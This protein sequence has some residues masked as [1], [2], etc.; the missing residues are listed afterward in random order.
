MKA[1]LMRLRLGMMILW[2]GLALL[3]AL[4]T[5]S[6]AL[7]HATLVRSNPAAN[8]VVAQIPSEIRL[9]FSEA[10]EPRFSSFML[11]DQSGKP[12]DTPA[13]QID[14]ADATQMAMRPGTLP[15]GLYIVAWQSVSATDGHAA[16]GSFPFT[17]GAALSGQAAASAVVETIPPDGTLIRWLNLLSLAM[18]VGGVG[19]VLLVWQ[20]S[21]PAGDLTIERRLYRFIGIGWLLLG[22]TGILMLLLQVS[23]A[24]Q[25]SLLGALSSPALGQIVL[26][27]RYGMLRI[28]RL[29]F[30]LIRGGVLFRQSAHQPWRIRLALVLGGLILLTN[31]LYSHANAAP[32]TLPAVLGDWLHLAF[33]ALWVGS[34]MQFFNVLAWRRNDAAMPILSTLVGHFSN[35]ARVAVAGLF[36]TGLY[37]AWLQVGSVEG[38]LTTLYGQAL[39]IKLILILPLLAIAA[40]NLTLTHRGLKAGQP[41]WAGRLRG[42]VGAE[43]ALTISILAAV[44]AM[45]SLN[46]PRNVLA[47]RAAAA[48][49]PPVENPISDMRMTEDLHI[50]FDISPGWSGE[51]TFTLSLSDHGG[52]PITD[53]S[54]IRLRFDNQTQDLGQSELHLTNQGG[55][56]YSAS[57]ANL[58][59]PGD[60]RIR[61]TIKRLDQYDVVVDFNP[62]L[63]A[64]PPLPAAPQSVP[65]PDRLPALLLT[66]LAA[67]GIGGFFIGHRV[68]QRRLLSGAGL[69]ASGLMM[70]GLV[71]LG[72]ATLSLVQANAA[73][74][75]R[76]VVSDAYV[77][78]APADISSS[79]YFSIQN[80][81]SQADQLIGVTCDVAQTAELHQTQIAN[82]I[83]QM[84]T[85]PQI[86]IPAAQ[87][88]ALQPGGY[89]LML[90]GLKHELVAGKSVTLTLTFKSGER[91]AISAPIR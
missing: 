31:S 1:A 5:V 2:T 9:W 88:V 13:S 82:D 32:D 36:V 23:A 20:P 39:F 42:L 4:A 56:L 65:L 14:P 16:Q 43:V 91:L 64:A 79:A 46:T 67:V 10:L 49:P 68:G 80:N 38:L 40:I 28:A 83:A 75:A 6:P 81:G 57:G 86:D 74:E 47:Q 27:T 33:S 41:I 89:H 44:G 59:I 7:A 29:D 53:A 35:F 19:F 21:M 24:A 50:M 8:A 90:S 76:L 85:L 84:H 26:G 66:G 48:L 71:F 3:A 60:W 34:L 30:W 54:L 45:T 17:I 61:T 63:Q 11:H 58:S 72:A 77:S 37:T 70:I 18:A 69:L 51:N 52:Q 78:A 73:P 15:D 22:V 87:A 25:T 12:L 62:T 55:G